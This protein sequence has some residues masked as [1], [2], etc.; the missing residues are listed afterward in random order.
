MD[1]AGPMVRVVVATGAR[2]LTIS[3]SGGWQLAE[4]YGT[5]VRAAPGDV[6][7]VEAPQ[8][9]LMRAVR[10]DGVPTAMR[11]GPFVLRPVDRASLVT[12]G[13]KR[14]RGELAILATDSGLVAVNRLPLEEYL[15]GV[16]PLEI[17]ARTPGDAAAVEAQAV[18]AR[19]YTVTR[20]APDGR[21]TWDLRASELDQVYGGVEAETPVGD[22][23]VARTRGLVLMYAGRTVNAPYHSTCGGTTAA[24]EDVWRERSD[25][26]YLRPVSDR[27]PGSDRSYCDLSPRYRWTR[28]FDRATLQGALDRY[29]RAYAS[30]PAGGAG[31]ARDVRSAGSTA[32]GRVAA[33]D[34]STDRGSW[35]LRGN[36]IRFVMR[37]GGEILPSTYFSV[38][39]TRD[40]AGAISR[41]VLR[42]AGNGH[43]VGM[44]QWGAI[45]RA[46]AGQDFETILRTY[47]P[48]TTVA[49]ME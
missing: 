26:P 47:Y 21:G 34:V 42:G 39:A 22:A 32:S 8:G 35:R 1:E 37:T 2:R 40:G 44:C 33:L 10:S 43:G 49:A 27:I 11:A 41:L 17:G 3:A 14:Y 16:V 36:E 48:G 38:E 29:L 13:G 20:I 15:R 23:A 30:V 5:M 12:L 46:R 19:S 18:A 31:V 45:G 4:G 28:T 9:G 25:A 7:T 6:W 24:P